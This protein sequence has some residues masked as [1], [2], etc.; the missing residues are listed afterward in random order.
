MRHLKKLITLTILIISFPVFTSLTNDTNETMSGLI[1]EGSNLKALV[2][3]QGGMYLK[4]GHTVGFHFDL[5]NRFAAHQRCNI[6]IKP[7]SGC[8]PWKELAEGRVDIVVADAGR[9]TIPEE[10]SHLLISSLDLNEY[11]QVWV[12]SKERYN[13]L[14]NMNH[15]F[16]YFQN[17]EEYTELV[18]SYY[19]RYDRENF[20]GGKVT[21][22]S[23]YDSLIKIYSASI[24]WDWRLLASLIYQE[25][26]FSISARSVKGAHGLMQIRNATAKQFNIEDLYDPEQNIKAGTLM[27]KRLMGLFDNPEIDSL[28]RVKFVLAAYNAGEGRVDDIRS[29]AQHLG[30]NHNQWDSTKVVLGQMKKSDKLPEGLLKLGSFKGTETV[31][32]VDDIISRYENYKELV[33]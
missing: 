10:Y 27:I 31:R 33:K 5:L 28:N 3:I 32:F 25:S 7:V 11:E 26:K 24:G 4:Q 12:V 23:P 20:K 8:D 30:V 14:Q 17:S 18:T 19:R 21:L 29:F 22:L 2:N 1:L 9:D 13:L 6:K 15:W 16:G